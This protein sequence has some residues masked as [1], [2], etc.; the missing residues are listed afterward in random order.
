MCVHAR[1]CKPKV[2]IRCFLSLFPNECLRQGLSWT[3]SLPLSSRGSCVCVLG[4]V[5]PDFTWVLGTKRRASFILGCWGP[6]GEL[7][8]CLGDGHLTAWVYFPSSQKYFKWPPLCK[9]KSWHVG[10]RKATGFFLQKSKWCL[11]LNTHSPI[12]RPHI[13]VEINWNLPHCGLNQ[14]FCQTLLAVNLR[15]KH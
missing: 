14:C 2:Y 4:T 7:H 13:Y 8:S 12:L 3:W 9:I 15:W 5:A 6:S 10:C 11:T 1:G